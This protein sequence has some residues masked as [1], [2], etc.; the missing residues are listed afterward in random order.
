MTNEASQDHEEPSYPA[1]GVA[2]DTIPSA[3]DEP[4][5][6]VDRDDARRARARAARHGHH[7][8]DAR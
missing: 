7:C 2:D 6:A 4:R 5:A 3:P 1:V 8:A